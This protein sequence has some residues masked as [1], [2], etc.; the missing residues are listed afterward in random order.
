MGLRSGLERAETPPL[1]EPFSHPIPATMGSVRSHPFQRRNVSSMG[2]S[3]GSLKMEAET[4]IWPF[5]DPQASDST[6]EKGVILLTGVTEPDYQGKLVCWYTIREMSETQEVPWSFLIPH[7][8][9]TKRNGNYNPIQA[10]PF[11]VK[12]LQEWSFWSLHQARIHTSQHT[13]WA[14][15][16]LGSRRK[17]L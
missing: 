9:V 4:V 11:T 1:S 2:H 16:K 14:Q 7:C 10:G 6:G 17:Q 15:Y 3:N 12:T 5:W 13:C 8:P